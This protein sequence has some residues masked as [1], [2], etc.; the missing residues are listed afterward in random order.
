VCLCT[1]KVLVAGPTR[2]AER[3]RWGGVFVGRA[4]ALLTACALCAID[5]GPT[6]NDVHV[7]ARARPAA[8]LETGSGAAPAKRAKAK[9]APELVSGDALAG[10]RA[11][12]FLPL[13]PST[14]EGFR[15]KAQPE[16]KDID[17]GEGA[18]L[19]VLK[20][21]YYKS[22]TALEIEVVDTEQS[23]PLR[24]LFDKTR[25]LERDTEAAVIKPIKVQGYKAIAQWNS[26]AKAA[27]VTVLVEG[28]Y[29]VNLSL[30]PADNITTS[31]SLAEKLELPEL[32]KL[33]AD[34]EIAAH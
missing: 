28:R 4:R 1:A 30:R 21:S 24:A 22:N 20:R 16:G 26:T 6:G 11:A 29:L 9:R 31:V 23:K 18:G 25:E 5:C 32:A 8:P 2:D 27:R 34:S 7:G 33:P 10:T 3:S 13:V 15:A 17:L 19:A 12:T 14:F